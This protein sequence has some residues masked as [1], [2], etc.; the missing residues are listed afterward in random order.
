LI[1]LNLSEYIYLLENETIVLLFS[2]QDA[3]IASIVTTVAIAMSVHARADG[4]ASFV[5]I[6]KYESKSKLFIDLFIQFLFLF[7]P[8]FLPSFFLSFFADLV[9]LSA[10]PDCAVR[11]PMRRL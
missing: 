2:P 10:V 6:A 5:H 11:C 4:V 1:A 9:A 8:S 7:L 3:T